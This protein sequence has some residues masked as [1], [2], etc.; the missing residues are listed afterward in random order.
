MSDQTFGA[1]LMEQHERQDATGALSRAWTHLRE[2]RGY[3]RTHTAKSIGQLLS[4]Q[5]GEDWQKL[6][7]DESITAAEAEWKTGTTLERQGDHGMVL[8]PDG[9]QP[10]GI[11]EPWKTPA[12]GEQ[13]QLPGMPSGYAVTGPDLE[14]MIAAVPVPAPAPPMAILVVDGYEYE[15]TPGRRY[16]LDLRPVLRQDSDNP[17][18]ARANTAT[19]VDTDIFAPAPQLIDDQGRLNF[20]VLYALAD[21]TLPEGADL[22]SLGLAGD[23]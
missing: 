13:L 10:Q 4:A 19:H 1:W 15:L 12:G 16:V 5:L 21:H 14:S 23:E 18:P 20:A 2:A 7:G 9:H 11:P 17:A 3:N 6:R 8:P 22:A